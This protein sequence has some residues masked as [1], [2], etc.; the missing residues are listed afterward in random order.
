MLGTSKSSCSTPQGL[1]KYADPEGVPPLL[2]SHWSFLV[3]SHVRVQWESPGHVPTTW[4]QERLLHWGGWLWTPSDIG[5]VF[6]M[7]GRLFTIVTDT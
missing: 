2:V 4:L 7:I 6:K 3:E 5:G 1:P